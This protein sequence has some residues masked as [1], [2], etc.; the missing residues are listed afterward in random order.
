MKKLLFICLIAASITFYVKQPI[1]TDM[2]ISLAES[3]VVDGNLLLV[4][5][6]IALQA[7][8]TN[9]VE[10]P[11]DLSPNVT[12]EERF[13][14]QQPML[15]ALTILF[16][17]ARDEGLQHFIINS[18]YRS[19]NLQSELFEKYGSDY[20]LPSGHS[21]HQTGL[22]I[23]IGSTQGTMDS[24]AEGKWLENNA[25]QYGFILRYP[26]DKVDITGIDYEP[27]HFRY[28]GLPHSIIMQ[29][30]NFVLEEYL[31]YIKKEKVFKA[32]VH[33]V[34]YVIQYSENEPTTSIPKSEQFTISG[35]NMDGFIIT[36]IVQ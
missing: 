34:H 30:K 25:A 14:V 16:D 28:V 27:W 12:V 24:V 23:D 13:L 4:N 7:D 8:P 11:Q 5:R 9:L 17:A 15:K 6:D 35:D 29:D 20:A 31:A 21:E 36:S 10:I 18:A 22:S 26:A 33:G 2:D 1:T 19:G 32:K 3:S